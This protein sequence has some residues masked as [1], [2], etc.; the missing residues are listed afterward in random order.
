MNTLQVH[1]ELADRFPSKFSDIEEDED[2][3]TVKVENSEDPLHF[4]AKQQY[5]IFREAPFSKMDLDESEIIH[6]YRNEN[7]VY[8]ANKMDRKDIS[9]DSGYYKSQGLKRC[10]RDEISSKP[11]DLERYDKIVLILNNIE[12]DSNGKL[13]NNTD[14]F[15]LANL[16]ISSQSDDSYGLKYNK[17]YIVLF[18]EFTVTL[19]CGKQKV[20]PIPKED[21]SYPFIN[22]WSNIHY[23]LKFRRVP[24]G[25]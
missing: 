14:I 23:R 15:S 17:S 2:E 7:L 20:I 19:W 4:V 6:T 8:G 21:D 25:P 16:N 11:E 12:Q 18:Q 1:L 3:F 10:F 22:S 9:M 24:F 13:R 5:Y